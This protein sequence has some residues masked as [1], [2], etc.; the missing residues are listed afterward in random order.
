MKSIYVFTI[1]A[2]LALCPSTAICSDADAPPCPAGH[3]QP[4][5]LKNPERIEAGTLYCVDLVE[6]NKSGRVFTSEEVALLC[7]YIDKG[8]ALLCVLDEESRM[9]L[10][11]D[12]IQSVIAKYGLRYTPDIPYLHNCGAVAKAG[13]INAA[14]RELPFSGGREILGGTPFAWRL[15]EAG[16]HAGPFAAYTETTGGGRIVALSEGMA[17][18]HLGTKE[19]VR[20]SGPYRDFMNTVYW[21]ADSVIFMEEVRAWLTRSSK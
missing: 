20:L 13:V 21:G 12:G 7:D 1:C 10:L 5:V 18:L 15:D 14:D 11:A 9:P 3:A 2:A 6:F 17:N 4:F 16:N 19:G 8:G